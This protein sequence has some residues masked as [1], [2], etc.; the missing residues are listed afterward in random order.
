MQRITR[1]RLTGVFD[2]RAP[3]VGYSL[4]GGVHPGERIVVE[5]E[6]SRGGLTRTPAAT[7]P[8]ALWAVRWRGYVG[9][10]VTGPIDV[11]GAR[12]GDTLL[13]HI[14]QQTCD[15]L[16]YQE[17]WPWRFHLEEFF[18]QPSTVLRDIRDGHVLLDHGVRVPV[19]PVIG[20]NGTAPA[21]EAILSAG[22]GRHG[23]NLDVP[24]IGPGS[25]V[26]LPVEVEGA[27]PALGDCH[28][29]QA[30]GEIGQVEMRSEVTLSCEVRPGRSPVMTWPRVETPDAL[31]AVA[32]ATP[33]EEALRLALREMILWLEELTGLS[34]HEA[35]L[36]VGAVG[37]ARPGQAQ[38]SHYSMRCIMPRA[39]LPGRPARPEGR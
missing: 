1:D 8:E 38:V 11:E 22:M 18:D 26:H 13:V 32:V 19:R 15:T 24:E 33:L 17:Y 39:Y 37:H 20:T 28:A 2:R 27:L 3:P 6:N 12:P 23:G 30:D 31:V 14:H 34:R 10:P 16:G 21:V 9:N 35:Y 36:L 4:A 5:T 7:T 29:V 25:T